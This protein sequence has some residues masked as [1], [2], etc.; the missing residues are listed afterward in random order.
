MIQSL[1]ESIDKFSDDFIALGYLD[2]PSSSLETKEQ[3][4]AKFRAMLQEK[5]VEQQKLIRKGYE[6]IIRELAEKKGDVAD[7]YRLSEERITAL[8]DQDQINKMALEMGTFQDLLHYTPDM[9]LVMYSIGSELFEKKSYEE[10]IQVYTFLTTLNHLCF[11]FWLGLGS[12]YEAV[13]KF[14]E[15]LASYKLA[16]FVAPKE[17]D[18]YL[19]TVRCCLACKKHPEALEVL[20]QGKRLAE[21]LPEDE[22]MQNTKK[23]ILMMID[24]IEKQEKGG[25]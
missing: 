19:Y 9:M 22:K 3:H 1:K 24:H 10:C 21:M 15:A 6:L 14:E 12:A 13:E 16:V 2:K 7:L 20:E 4:R 23:E 11:Y 25:V 8:R 17:V 18:P 5:M